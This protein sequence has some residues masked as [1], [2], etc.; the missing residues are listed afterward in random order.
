MQTTHFLLITI[1]IRFVYGSELYRLFSLNLD[2]I[3]KSVN[4]IEIWEACFALSIG[5]RER[6]F[7]S[8]S[9]LR[10]KQTLDDKI[11]SN[12]IGRTWLPA[13]KENKE[14]FEESFNG[15]PLVTAKTAFRHRKI[16]EIGSDQSV[17]KEVFDLL[18][19]DRWP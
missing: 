3:L 10:E 8:L 19:I 16:G 2:Y 9:H 18:Q 15:V 11:I 5:D 13:S 17:Q 7:I 12:N 1:Q 4:K 14:R 6:E